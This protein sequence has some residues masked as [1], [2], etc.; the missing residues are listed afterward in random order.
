MNNLAW[1]GWGPELC[2]GLGMTTNE[3][4]KV[5]LAISSS[6]DT[7][8]LHDS[9]LSILYGGDIVCARGSAITIQGTGTHCD[10]I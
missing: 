4:N 3:D 9:T 10:N 2:N 5:T 1:C 8:Q 7:P 6:S